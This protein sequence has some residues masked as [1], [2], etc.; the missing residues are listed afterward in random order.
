[1]SV[2]ALLD[3]RVRPDVAD[4][5]LSV[6]NDVLV[7]TRAFEGSLGVDVLVDLADPT[8]FVLVERWASIESDDA[9]RAWRST[10][11][12][13]SALGELLAETPRLT[14]F[15]SAEGAVAAG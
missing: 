1:M 14:R 3:L 15:T 4:T 10:P 7:A 12:G 2:T 6:I 9:Y 8:H 13:R 5:A 11:E